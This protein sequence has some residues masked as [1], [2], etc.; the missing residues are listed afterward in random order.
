MNYFGMAHPIRRAHLPVAAAGSALS[1]ERVAESTVAENRIA[2][3]DD[4]W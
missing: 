1:G 4:A 2:V 3:I